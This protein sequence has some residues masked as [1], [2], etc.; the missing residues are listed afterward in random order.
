LVLIHIG[1]RAEP[2]QIRQHPFC[3]SR[4]SDTAEGADAWRVWRQLGEGPTDGA[5]QENEAS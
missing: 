3:K 2:V 5:C 4:F 1:I